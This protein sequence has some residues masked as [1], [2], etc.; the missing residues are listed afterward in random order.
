METRFA[1][2]FAPADFESMAEDRR[3]IA[4]TLKG[5]RIVIGDLSRANV[6]PPKLADMLL[7]KREGIQEPLRNALLLPSNRPTLAMQIDR[8]IRESANPNRRAFDTREALYVW[9]DAIL[10]P[11]ER[12]RMRDFFDEGDAEPRG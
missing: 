10:T 9:L 1:S 12:T 4:L 7:T 3:R 11:D 6:M 2:P 5:E 8:I